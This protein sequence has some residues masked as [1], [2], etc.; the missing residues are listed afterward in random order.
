MPMV[1]VN[2]FLLLTDRECWG[3]IQNNIVNKGVWYFESPKH[4]FIFSR[5]NLAHDFGNTLKW[6]EMWYGPSFKDT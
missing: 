1:R 6:D 4:L 3:F 2:S 5:V